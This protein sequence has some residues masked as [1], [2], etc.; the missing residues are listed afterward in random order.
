VVF[1]VGNIRSTKRRPPI[2]GGIVDGSLTC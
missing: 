2:E 1:V